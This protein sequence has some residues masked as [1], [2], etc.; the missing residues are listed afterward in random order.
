MEGRPRGRGAMGNWD[1]WKWVHLHHNSQSKRTWKPLVYT[2]KTMTW[3]F[4]AGFNPFCPGHFSLLLSQWTPGRGPSRT[5]G[6]P[7]STSQVLSPGSAQQGGLRGRACSW[8]P[9]LPGVEGR[10]GQ[11]SVP[12]QCWLLP[13][14]HVG[15]SA[16]R[17]TTGLARPLSVCVSK[18]VACSPSPWGW[19]QHVL[20]P[21]LVIQLPRGFYRFIHFFPKYV[22]IPCI[23]FSSLHQ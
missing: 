16:S 6:S 18:Y 3:I 21:Y 15:A 23:I 19:V 2:F 10:W 9:V 5:M 1:S 4:K 11:R 22:I 12:V 8:K 13:H 20:P 7:I 14:W 17:I